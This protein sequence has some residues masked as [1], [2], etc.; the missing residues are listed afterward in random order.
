MALLFAM[1]I[2]TSTAVTIEGEMEKVKSQANN[3]SYGENTSDAVRQ[4]CSLYFG[5]SK[6]ES[7]IAHVAD[8]YKTTDP[9]RITAWSHGAVPAHASEEEDGAKAMMR[10]FSLAGMFVTTMSDIKGQQREELRANVTASKKSNDSDSVKDT[11]LAEREHADTTGHDHQEL[12]VQRHNYGCEYCGYWHPQ[13][14]FPFPNCNFCGARPSYHHGR[15]CPSRRR[16]TRLKKE[17]KCR[18]REAVRKELRAGATEHS[19]PK[20]SNFLPQIVERRKESGSHCSGSRTDKYLVIY[21]PHEDRRTD[22]HARTEGQSRISH[23][24]KMR[25]S[26]FLIEEK[27]SEAT[28]VKGKSTETMPDHFDDNR[29]GTQPSRPRDGRYQKGKAIPKIRERQLKGMEY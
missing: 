15:C 17:T 19:S 22:K 16:S 25:R 12:S 21:V 7:L 18:R 10:S 11:F 14:Q 28:V 9:E 8:T 24:T 13:S 26:P 1:I 20:D 23:D 5:E 2:K 3:I 27:D 29:F 4:Q 6:D